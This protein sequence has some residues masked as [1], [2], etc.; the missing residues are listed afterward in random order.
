MVDASA[1]SFIKLGGDV[2][3]GGRAAVVKDLVCA[4]PLDVF[5]VT[6]QA[7]SDDLKSSS[8]SKLN[9]VTANS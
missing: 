8:L 4:K 7:G 3:C 9:S 1:C 2:I 5:E 6:R